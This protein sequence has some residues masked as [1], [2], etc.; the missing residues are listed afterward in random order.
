MAIRA[1]WKVNAVAGPDK[2]QNRPERAA[3]L[4]DALRRNLR[5]RKMAAVPS[6]PGGAPD[7]PKPEDREPPRE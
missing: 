1:R 4:A 6:P 3:R 7:Q 2:P 5:K